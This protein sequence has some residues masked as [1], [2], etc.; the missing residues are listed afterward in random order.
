[1]NRL[2]GTLLVLCLGYVP[3]LAADPAVVES[4]FASEDVPLRLDPVS[5]FWSVARPISMEKDPLG[6]NEPR[7]RSE[8]RSRWTKHNLYFLFVCPYEELH[9]RPKPN[10]R[11]ETNELWNWDVAEVFVGSDFADIQRYKEFEVS[12]Q[13]EWVDLDINL[14][15]PHHEDGWKWNSGFETAAR[16]DPQAKI[17]YAAMRI[18]LAAI[19]ARPPAPGNTLRI[20]FF[21]SQGTPEHLHEITWQPPMSKSFHV[22]EHFGL[23]KLVGMAH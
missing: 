12:P 17:W 9:L 4:V 18:P 10:T 3:S 13:G 20:N 16:I 11:E 15:D 5:A 21:R 6:K 1:M 7:Y 23:L 22:P 8:V 2:T 19:D 14:H